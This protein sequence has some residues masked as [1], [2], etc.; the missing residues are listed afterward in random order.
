[1]KKILFCFFLLPACAEPVVAAD[2]D[3]GYCSSSYPI[4]V[5]PDVCESGPHGDCCS[6]SDVETEDGNCRYDYCAYFANH[7]CEWELQY[8]ECY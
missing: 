4:E 6:W 8:K 2:D 1:M 7:E 3:P 5:A